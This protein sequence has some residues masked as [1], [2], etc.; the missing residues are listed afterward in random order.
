MFLKPRT[1]CNYT[2]TAKT[3]YI[4]STSTGIYFSTL[5]TEPYTTECFTAGSPGPDSMAS[6]DGV[7]ILSLKQGCS[8]RFTKLGRVYFAPPQTSAPEVVPYGASP[9]T[10]GSQQINVLYAMDNETRVNWEK[11]KK[12][13]DFLEGTTFV[14]ALA[15]I[16]GTTAAMIMG[17]RAREHIREVKKKMMDSLQQYRIESHKKHVARFPGNVFPPGHGY[18]GTLKRTNSAANLTLP[19]PYPTPP[20]NLISNPLPM[21]P[22]QCLHQTRTME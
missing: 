13:Q 1:A 4:K 20:M 21:P 10:M 18:P 19:A 11:I 8:V 2:P 3:S 6:L 14:L 16:A 5:H 7:G 9:Y 17:Y 12:S 15:I 22:P